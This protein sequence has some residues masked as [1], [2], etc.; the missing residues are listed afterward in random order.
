MSTTISWNIV[1]LDCYPQYESQSD[2]VFNVH[3]EVVSSE[4]K[5]YGRCYGSIG[6]ELDPESPF[7]P[8]D[9]LT[10]DQVIGWV[11]NT[12]G[13]EKVASLEATVSQQIADQKSPPIVA[14]NLPWQS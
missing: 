14:P 8:Y 11:K 1:Q 10:K 4:D 6:V 9:Q 3:W 2:V 12:M 5:Y 7:T 13:E